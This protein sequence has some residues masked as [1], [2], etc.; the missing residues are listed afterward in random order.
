MGASSNPLKEWLDKSQYQG[1]I[2]RFSA[3]L[4]I[5]QKTVEDWFYRGAKPGSPN[6]LR[7]YLATGLEEYSPRTDAETRRLREFE[8]EESK[9]LEERIRV[10][11]SLINSVQNEIDYFREAPLRKR[12]ALRRYLD[13][14]QIAYISNLLQLLLNEE[15]FNEWLIMSALSLLPKDGGGRR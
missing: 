15:R 10:F 6:K 2:S 13:G 8:Q 7:L 11:L 3:A 1:S 12:E 4:G 14:Q 5:P 9:T